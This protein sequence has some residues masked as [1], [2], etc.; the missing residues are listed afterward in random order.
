[1]RNWRDEYNVDFSSQEK[2]GRKVGW[3]G[4]NKVHPAAIYR[5]RQMEFRIDVIGQKV[6]LAVFRRRTKGSKAGG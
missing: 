1:M 6:V 4:G 3:H 2:D 5:R